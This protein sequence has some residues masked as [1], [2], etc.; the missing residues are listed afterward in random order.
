MPEFIFD[1]NKSLTNK[2]KYGID[3]MEA[4]LLWEDIDRI[5]VPA[6]VVDELRFLI[7]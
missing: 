1:K 6:K 7:K 2:N 3:F 5:I 4:Q